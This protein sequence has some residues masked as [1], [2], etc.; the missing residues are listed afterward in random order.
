[1]N[2]VG[3]RELR[4]HLREYL[5]RVEAGERFEVTVFDRSVAELGPMAANQ[6]SLEQLIAEGRVTPA[7]IRQ[8]A[9]LPELFPVTAGETATETLLAERRS[10][11]R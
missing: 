9:D 7:L 2:R 3:M 4:H 6:A 8:P 5:S 1:M 10:D 11:G